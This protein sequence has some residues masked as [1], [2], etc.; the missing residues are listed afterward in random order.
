MAV[1]EAV[2]R[3]VR[4][5]RETGRLRNTLVVFTS[6]NGYL[7]GDHHLLGKDKPYTPPMRVPMVMRWDGRLQPGSSDDRFALN[8]DIAKTIARATGTSYASDGVNLLGTYRR[9][10]FLL[11]AAAGY[12]GRPPYCGW[13][14]KQ[15]MFAQY[16]TGERELYDLSTDPHELHNLAADPRFADR[17]A[18]LRAKSMQRCQPT[19]PGFSW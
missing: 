12:H 15:W 19:P 7:W 6:D 13:R 16:A 17:L 2:A 18:A 4:A 5:L 1:D 10:G 11:E 14:T 9:R 3:L 8:V